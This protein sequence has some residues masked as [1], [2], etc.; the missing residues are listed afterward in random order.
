MQC[1][2]NS[3][4]TFQWSSIG[5]IKDGRGEMGEEMPVLVYRMMQYSMLDVLSKAHG[6][7][8][9]NDYFRKAG[10]LSGREFATHALNLG[11]GF[12]T[13]TTNLQKVLESMKIGILHTESFD[14]E[15]GSIVLTVEKDLDCSGLPNTNETVC[16]FDEGFISGILEAY[17]G[18]VYNVREVNCCAN[19]DALCRFSGTVQTQDR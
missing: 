6:N 12:N 8:Q 15:T 19:G 9:A 11:A 18:R 10:Y 2:P 1:K 17:T 5:N 7:E 14:R 3:H 4:Y 13:F 16:N